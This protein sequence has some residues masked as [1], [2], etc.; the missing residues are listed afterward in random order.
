MQKAGSS[1]QTQSVDTLSQLGIR[2][3]TSYDQVTYCSLILYVC[4]HIMLIETKLPFATSNGN[5][6]RAYCNTDPKCL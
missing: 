6:T 1:H 5:T 4:K 3:R 2:I